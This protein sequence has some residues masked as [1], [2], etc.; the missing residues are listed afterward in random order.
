MFRNL[1]NN[2]SIHRFFSQTVHN[3]PLKSVAEQ[4]EEKKKN[5]EF[6]KHLNDMQKMIAEIKTNPDK[7][8]KV[9]VSNSNTSPQ[10]AEA[11]ERRNRMHSVYG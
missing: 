2:K 10:E 6:L 5:P 3:Y 7:Y 11:E 9:E 4:L 1:F 8:P